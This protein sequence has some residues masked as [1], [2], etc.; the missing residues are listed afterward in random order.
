MRTGRHDPGARLL[1]FTP[2]GGTPAEPPL[3]VVLIM[4]D[5]ARGCAPKSDG[6]SWRRIV[7]TALDSPHDIVTP[8]HEAAVET[9]RCCV[10]ARCVVV[11][12]AG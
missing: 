10:Q 4:N 6:R 2:G 8:A 9:E 1:A 5:T 11:L 7:Y 3:H 12:E